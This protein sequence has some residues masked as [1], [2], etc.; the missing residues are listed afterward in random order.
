M[1][2]GADS[3]GLARA[4]EHSLGLVHV[5]GRERGPNIFQAQSVRSQRRW[6]GLDSHRGLLSAADRNQANAG[7]LG[8]FLRES[9]VRKVF[10]LRKRQCV[11]GQ[12]QRQNR[13]ICRIHLAIDRRVGQVTRQIGCGRIDRGLDLLFL[14][15]NV[16]VEIELQRDD[17][18]AQG[19]GGGHLAQAWDLAKLALQRC[20]H[21]RCHH[22]RVGS[23]IERDHL[24]GWVINFRKRGNRKLG[25]GNQPHQQQPDHQQSCSN[26]AKDKNSR[27]AHGAPVVEGGADWGRVAEDGEFR[28]APP[29][30]ECGSTLLPACS[31]SCP[32]TTTTS[33]GAIPLVIDATLF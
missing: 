22:V 17:G 4:I 10:H 31:L 15:V 29:P 1:I 9:R 20:R 8:D 12:R 11:G 23:R 13:G 30:A 5:G 6:I 2:I 26:R 32:S 19:T 16:L 3:E 18:A 27:R 7:K 33:P 21:R 24:N 28:F 25:V 14:D